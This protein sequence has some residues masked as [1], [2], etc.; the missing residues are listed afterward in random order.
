MKLLIVFTVGNTVG[1]FCY[2]IIWHSH[3]CH[4]TLG[5][6]ALETA[7]LPVCPRDFVGLGLGL[8]VA[9]VSIAGPI[10]KA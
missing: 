6:E 4:S 3:P 8:L 2:S 5:Q 10:S 7:Q 1:L 9:P